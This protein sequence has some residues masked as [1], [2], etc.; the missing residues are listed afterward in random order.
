MNKRNTT[1]T[2]VNS[3]S[4][5]PRSPRVFSEIRLLMLFDDPVRYL[6]RDSREDAGQLRSVGCVP[7]VVV[8]TGMRRRYA[9]GEARV[10]RYFRGRVTNPTAGGDARD[11]VALRGT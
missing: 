8:R 4:T 5:W 9:L 1:T 3:T 11:R 10:S 6:R 2:S 7:E